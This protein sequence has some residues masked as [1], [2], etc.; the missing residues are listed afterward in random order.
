MGTPT[1]PTESP[2]ETRPSS[3]HG[4]KSSSRK[5]LSTPTSQAILI[6]TSD[7]GRCTATCL[8]T[9]TTTLVLLCTLCRVLLET[10]KA[11][12]QVGLPLHGRPTRTTLPLD[13]RPLPST[14]RLPC[15]GSGVLQPPTKSSTLSSSPVQSPLKPTNP[16]K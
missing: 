1:R 14:T 7:L 4:S 3:K 16:T 10:P 13:T 6:C 5:P 12:A 15:S 2:Q 9:R 8:C 11:T